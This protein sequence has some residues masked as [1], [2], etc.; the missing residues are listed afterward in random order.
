MSSTSYSMA[1]LILMTTPSSPIY[2]LR[3][4]LRK[5]VTAPAASNLCVAGPGFQPRQAAP[6]C[7]HGEVK[8]GMG[9]CGGVDTAGRMARGQLGPGVRGDI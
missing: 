9:I 7:P 6:L 5:T 1:H 3:L 2:K 8:Q 4:R